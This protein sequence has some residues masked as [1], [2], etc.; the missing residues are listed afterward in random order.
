[1]RVTGSPSSPGRCRTRYDSIWNPRKGSDTAS[2]AVSHF[3]LVIPYQP[4]TTSR[5]GNPCCGGSGAPFI[6]YARI[7]SSPIASP[8]DRLSS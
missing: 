5:S 6:A 4:G 1:M 8:I 7:T 3:T 2:T